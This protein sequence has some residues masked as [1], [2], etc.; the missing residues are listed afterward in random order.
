MSFDVLTPPLL[1]LIFYVVALIFTLYSVILAYHW[2][3]YGTSK[4]I[5][6]LSLSIYLLGSA[7]LFI[8]MSI[9]LNFL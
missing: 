1:H 5:S 9:S 8:A 4:K 6:T 2:Y 7:A 3:F